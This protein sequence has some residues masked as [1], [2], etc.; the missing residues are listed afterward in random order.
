VAAAL[1]ASLSAGASGGGQSAMVTLVVVAFALSAAVY[2]AGHAALAVLVVV[3]WQWLATADDALSPL[4]IATAT[5]LFVFHV[6]IALLASTPVGAAL[7][8]AVLVRWA[9]RTAIVGSASMVMWGAVVLMDQRRAAGSVALTFA[10]FAVAA[11]SIVA[12]IAALR[13]D[14]PT[15]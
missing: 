9:Q 11:A 13:R 6:L 8:R 12:L 5:D 15:G 10:G 4:A 2:P 14:Q 3:T 7:D 1:V